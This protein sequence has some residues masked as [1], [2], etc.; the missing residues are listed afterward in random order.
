MVGVTS[1][2]ISPLLNL[3]ASA[4]VTNTNDPFANLRTPGTVLVTGVIFVVI[5]TASYVGGRRGKSLH[6]HNEKASRARER[7]R[8]REGVES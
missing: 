2:A 6:V 7:R 3:G 1:F 8:S 4:L 5:L